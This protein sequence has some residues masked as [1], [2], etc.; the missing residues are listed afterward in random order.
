MININAPLF[1]I[2][3]AILIHCM[4]QEKHFFTKICLGITSLNLFIGGL[5]ILL[6]S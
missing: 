6:F 4:Q 2:A 3:G 1:Y 5:L